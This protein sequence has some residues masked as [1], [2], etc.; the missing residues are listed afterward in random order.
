[1][2]ALHSTIFLPSGIYQYIAVTKLIRFYNTLYAPFCT[3]FGS[4]F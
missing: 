3:I 4:N 1:M 2:Q